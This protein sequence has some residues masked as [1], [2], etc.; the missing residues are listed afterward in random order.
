[1]TL[2][3]ACRAILT[4]TLDHI[5]IQSALHQKL[6]VGQTAGVFFKNSHE[7]LTNCFA[8]CFWLSNSSKSFEKPRTSIDMNQL[9]SHHPMK[10]FDDLYAFVF[11]HQTRV[12][13]NAGQLFADRPMYE[14]CGNR[15][16]NATRQTTHNSLTANLLT[17]CFDLCVN[18]RVHCPTWR[19]ASKLMNK[20]LQNFS[21]LLRM[22]HLRVKLH[23]P[24]L[25][26]RALNNSHRRI[27]SCRSG[28]K[29]IGYACDCIK[30]T[31]PHI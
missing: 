9:D 11:A 17:N 30:V 7:Q 28:N 12:N 27:W 24:N 10:C 26:C 29:T 25:F 14:R 21:A 4:A 8:F 31:H 1:M 3:H 2:N 18:D 15:R 22:H 16:V 19:T 6:R 23:S 5:G 20:P 13:I